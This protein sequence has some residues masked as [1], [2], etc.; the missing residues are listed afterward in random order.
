MKLTKTSIGLLLAI[1]LLSLNMR[2]AITSIGPL[3]D[4]IRNDLALSNSE[5]SL[6]TSIPVICMGLFAPLAVWWL[7][8]FGQKWG[9]T[10]LVLV[11]GIFTALRFVWSAYMGLLLTSF[12]VGIAIAIMGPILSSFIK[13]RFASQTPLAISVYSLGMGG[14]ATLSAGLTGYF[15]VG[16]QSNWSAALATWGILAVIS[17]IV[18]FIVYKPQ[19]VEKTTTED[20]FIEPIVRSPWKN[21][22]AW[23]IML[24]FGFQ[25][26]L[27][28]AL[29]TWLGSIAGEMGYSLLKAGSTITLMTTV[30][31]FFNLLVPFLMNKNPNRLFWIFVALSIG[32]VGLLFMLTG[33]PNLIWVSAVLLG[34]TLAVL[35]PVGL[36]LPLD[37]TTNPFEANE[38]S[39][40]V[41][42]GGFV[43]GG[44][45][46][47]VIGILYDAT[48][49]HTW[50]I[51]LMLLMM[52][53][54]AIFTFLLKRAR[55][56]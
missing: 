19:I 2:P 12:V 42:S 37:E 34:I 30:Q 28:F 38:W 11:I 18:W 22:R 33:I 8:R 26:A 35:F 7:R 48:N 41:L 40:M 5:I 49:S 45:F 13:E 1:F 6:L 20:V 44:I 52:V 31:L 36:L 23:M 14:G 27:F 29:T 15:Y 32:T 46:P 4:T 53:M 51:L 24:F 39:A 3:L 17:L 54:M 10:L 47:L 43:I 9:I 16:Y 50:T 21:Y 56:Q 55:E 25:C